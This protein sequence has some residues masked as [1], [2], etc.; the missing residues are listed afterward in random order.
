MAAVDDAA[1]SGSRGEGLE[2]CGA[3]RVCP[4]SGRPTGGARAPGGRSVARRRPAAGFRR[5]DRGRAVVHRRARDRR[6]R[7]RHRRGCVPGPRR[8]HRAGRERRR[9]P[10]APRGDHRRPDR[11]H[12]DAG[13]R[14]HPR[15]P[16]L[17]AL[18]ELGLRKLHPREPHRPPAPP[19]LLR[20][21][22]DHLHRQRPRR[23]RPRSPAGATGGRGRRRPLP[24]V[25]RP[26]DSRRRTEP[27][28]HQRRRMVGAARGDHP[29]R[30][31]RGR[32]GRG[33]AR[34]PH[35]EDLGGRT[36]RAAGARG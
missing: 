35:P 33:R 18:H 12:G 19:R 27:P 2:V 6:R 14:Q 22:H 29:C 21:R 34:R 25:A 10:A 11:A 9:G 8:S 4:A 1:W 26:R 15:A 31:A 5:R 3:R 28:V 30:G 23:H 7:E 17:G 13:A 32:A 36:R 16:R 24:G 20:R